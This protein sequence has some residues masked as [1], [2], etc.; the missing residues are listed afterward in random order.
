MQKVITINLN[1]NAYQLDEDAYAALVAYLERSAA[2]LRDNPDLAEIMA[3]LEQ[4]IGDKCQRYLGAH[5]SVVSADEV[6]KILEEMG[7]VAEPPGAEGAKGGEGRDGNAGERSGAGG[8]DGPPHKRL[9]QLH[10]DGMISGVCAGLAAYIGVDVA[11]VRIVFVLLALVTKGVWVLAYV[12]MMFVIPYAETPEERAAARG[13]PFSAKDLVEDA[14]RQYSDF[15][16]RHASRHEWRRRWRQ[17]RRE[18]RARMRAAAYG[19][20]RWWAEHVEHPP[21]YATQVLGGILVPL[22]SVLSAA[23]FFLMLWAL[24]SLGTRGEVFGVFLPV[25]IPLWAGILALFLVYQALVAPL[26]FGRFAARRLY[27]RYDYGWV[28][29]WDGLMRIGFMLVFFWLAY[30]YMPDFRDF[31]NNV[32]DMLRSWTRS[33]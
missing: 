14:K 30:A 24:I 16:G 13:H 7:P 8:H 12:I 31:V 23:L 18:W 28:A 25:G 10:D 19:P 29:A 33:L 32:P 3:D 2:Q 21:H 15:A 4:A 27:G 20:S 11:I 6:R 1:G 17:Q 26:M 9:Y 5:K 22:V